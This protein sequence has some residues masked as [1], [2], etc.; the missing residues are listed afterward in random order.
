LKAAV[1]IDVRAV[2]QVCAGFGVA[3]SSV[4]ALRAG[5]VI[6][7]EG[8]A[9]M[10]GGEVRIRLLG[11]ALRLRSRRVAL[12]DR[13]QL[14]HAGAKRRIRLRERLRAHARLQLRTLRLRARLATR[15][16]GRRHR[17]E[18]DGRDEQQLPN[19][20]NLTSLGNRPHQ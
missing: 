7:S 8:F 18:H 5:P 4:L 20:A 19:H 3:C 1:P 6:L 15:S 13:G 14:G 17:H 9:A 10:R 11:L 16:H 12:V 2:R